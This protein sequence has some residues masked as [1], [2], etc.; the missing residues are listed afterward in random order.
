MF[1]GIRI[2]LS[3]FFGWSRNHKTLFWA[4]VI[5]FVIMMALTIILQI[6][7]FDAGNYGMGG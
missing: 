1:N 5:L 2:I 3:D 7:K 4:A 6:P